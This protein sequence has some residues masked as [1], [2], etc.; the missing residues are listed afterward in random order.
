MR[1]R[2]DEP[3]ELE[4]S[5]G[6]MYSHEKDVNRGCGQAVERLLHVQEVLNSTPNCRAFG[7]VKE[8]RKI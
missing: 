8:R 3:K 5:D 4:P 7:V 2:E 6:F 1:V